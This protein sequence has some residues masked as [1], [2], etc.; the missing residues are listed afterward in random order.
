MS[1]VAGSESLESPG[2]AV[3]ECQLQSQW[4]AQDH[5]ITTKDSGASGVD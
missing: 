5:G 1:Q 3:G 2:E 4:R